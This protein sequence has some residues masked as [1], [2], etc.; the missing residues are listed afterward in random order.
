MNVALHKRSVQALF[1]EPSAAHW[2][3]RRPPTRVTSVPNVDAHHCGHVCN[4]MVKLSVHAVHGLAPQI[5][6]STWQT[7]SY[8][9]WSL[10]T[11]RV[12]GD[13]SLRRAA[14]KAAVRAT[15]RL[16]PPLGL[17]L[18]TTDPLIHWPLLVLCMHVGYMYRAIVPA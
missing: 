3:Q 8:T 11:W 5:S 6:Q 12:W 9:F 16:P 17:P 14:K 15:L 7:P 1:E 2:S 4:H 13:G 18:D 10:D